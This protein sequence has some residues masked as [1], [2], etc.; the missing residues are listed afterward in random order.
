MVLGAR[1]S[2]RSMAPRVTLY[3]SEVSADEKETERTMEV[4][5]NQ[6]EADDFSPHC[7]SIDTFLK[8]IGKD[9][10]LDADGVEDIRARLL[11]NQITTGE[12][13]EAAVREQRLCGLFHPR[14]T[15]AIVA[16]VTGRGLPMFDLDEFMETRLR[17][18]NPAKF[19]HGA[20]FVHR[21]APVPGTRKGRIAVT[22]AF[23][24][25]LETTTVAELLQRLELLVG[26]VPVDRMRLVFN[27][28]SMAT[29]SSLQSYDVRSG[30]TLYLYTLRDPQTQVT[31]TGAPQVLATPQ[32]LHAPL[33]VG[34][35]PAA[36][37]V[38]APL[39]MALL[40]APSACGPTCGAG[41]QVSGFP[42]SPGAAPTQEQRPEALQ[43]GAGEPEMGRAF[44]TTPSTGTHVV[45]T[46]VSAPQVLAPQVAAPVLS[47]VGGAVLTPAVCPS[48]YG[49]VTPGAQLAVGAGGYGDACLVAQPIDRRVET[50]K[51]G[52]YTA[53][54]YPA[55][56]TR[57]TTCAS[58]PVNYQQTSN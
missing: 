36:A 27:G 16:R 38:R 26:D 8:K 42:V 21:I 14:V 30:D 25:D 24:L 31:F 53:F 52:S 37:P 29:T 34:L 57:V 43:A 46:Q 51:C 45:P 10:G 1:R 3:P 49:Y 23:D 9:L 22:W 7:P 32:P 39:P 18:K 19:L 58:C 20:I 28:F 5:A 44:L 33:P 47:A 35:A 15:E 55:P 48:M 12:A 6:E 2:G 56:G 40:C 41:A 13:L 11:V 50:C 54:R 4:S 17:V